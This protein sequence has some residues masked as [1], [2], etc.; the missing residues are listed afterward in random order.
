MLQTQTVAPELVE[1]LMKLMNEETFEGFA[2]AGGTALAL[3][4]GHRNS[5]DIDMFGHSEINS[6][7]FYDKLSHFGEV[8]ERQSSQNIYISEINKIKV[9]FVNYSR[10]SQIDEI[11][12]ID[13]IRMFT[14]KEIAAMKLN[15]IAGRGS[16][17]DFIDLYFLLKTFSL[18][19]MIDFYRQKYTDSSEFMMLKSL[20]YFEDADSQFEP[21]VFQE[22]DWNECK[23]LIL[24]EIN[25]L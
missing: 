10:F 14:P 23:K 1:L 15:A 12:E 3:Q 24:S 20:S 22:F 4:L 25:K 17:K 9:D 2:L 19:E 7:L 13:G 11:I 6:T 8:T 16:R 21:Q 18:E 5:V